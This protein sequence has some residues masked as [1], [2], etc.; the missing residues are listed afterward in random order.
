MLPLVSE[1]C[2]SNVKPERR[3]PIRATKQSL[4]QRLDLGVTEQNG[5][6][7]P[8]N[9]YRAWIRSL[10]DSLPLTPL[11]HFLSSD[12]RSLFGAELQMPRSEIKTLSVAL[13]GLYK[14]GW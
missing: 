10:P 13:Q 3:E 5:G 9:G 7:D 14:A 11:H 6:R 2:S 1:D 12:C 4:N 8:I